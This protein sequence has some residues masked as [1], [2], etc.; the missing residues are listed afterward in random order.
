MRAF[1]AVKGFSSQDLPIDSP[2]VM[3]D[4]RYT[5]PNITRDPIG[6]IGYSQDM[7]NKRYSCP[8]G[9]STLS[10]QNAD[11]ANFI[12]PSLTCITN[13]CLVG[14]SRGGPCEYV[15]NCYFIASG[16]PELGNQQDKGFF[17]DLS[18]NDATPESELFKCLNYQC[19]E[20]V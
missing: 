12:A 9:F 6:I 2:I 17:R 8:A 16:Y 14:C 15:N 19:L 7:L 11:Q 1:G 13:H 5:D 3:A 4:A 20:V 10:D 18:I